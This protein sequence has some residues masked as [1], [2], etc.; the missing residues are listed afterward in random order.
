[1]SS[2]FRGIDLNFD[3]QEEGAKRNAVE[4]SGGF[5]AGKRSA[6]FDNDLQYQCKCP[7]PDRFPY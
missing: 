6:S 4:L 7:G 1:M 3:I 2:H 5:V